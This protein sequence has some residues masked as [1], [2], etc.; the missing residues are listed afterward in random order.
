MSNWEKVNYGFNYFVK[1]KNDFMH[2][3]YYYIEYICL[4]GV[5][6]YTLPTEYLCSM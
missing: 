2:I 1:K 6:I 5:T 3:I 4:H